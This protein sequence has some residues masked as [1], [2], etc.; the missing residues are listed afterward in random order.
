MPALEKKQIYILDY[1]SKELPAKVSD[2]IHH[3]AYEHAWSNDNYYE[4]RIE[5]PPLEIKDE[6]RYKVIVNTYLLNKGVKLK[7]MV[8]IKLAW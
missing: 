7:E 1:Q 4:W 6:I 8:F 3:I 5:Q 2:A